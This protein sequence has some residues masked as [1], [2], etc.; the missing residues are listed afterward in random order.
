MEVVSGC[1]GGSKKRLTIRIVFIGDKLVCWLIKKVANAAK[2][3]STEA[4]TIGQAKLMA[5]RYIFDRRS[6]RDIRLSVKNA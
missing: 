3:F 4:F 5:S 1:N 2:V 6:L